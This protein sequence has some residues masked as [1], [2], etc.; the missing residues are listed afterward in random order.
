MLKIQRLQEIQNLPTLP[1]VILNIQRLIMSEEGDA[2]LLAKII[3]H[4]PPLTAKILRV[5]NSAFYGTPNSG[6]ISSIQLAITRIGFNEVGHIAMAVNI[7]K[8]FSH[9]SDILDYKEFWKHALKAAFFCNNI[10]SYLSTTGLI[11]KEFRHLFFLAGLLHDIGILIYEQFFHE[12]FDNIIKYAISKELSFLM[13]EKDIIPSETHSVIGAELL[14]MWKIEPSVVSAVRFH[15][16]PEKSSESHK[17]IVNTIHLC[18]YFLCN[19]FLGSFEGAFE[20]KSPEII[21][22]LHM[23]TEEISEMLE[24]SE[25]E[26]EESE[27]ISSIDK[28]TAFLI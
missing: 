25:K 6:K 28:K 7:I 24:K 5:A 14:N 21:T 11:P 2:S 10:A 20:L 13:A 19:S 1:E 8:Q 9:K 16:T 3:E 26:T 23:S 22:Q 18:E 27:I 4:D 17:I 15:H 12:Q